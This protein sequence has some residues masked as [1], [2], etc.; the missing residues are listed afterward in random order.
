MRGDR[1]RPG[2]RYAGSLAVDDVPALRRDGAQA[3]T[4][5]TRLDVRLEATSAVE[6]LD[7]LDRVQRFAASLEEMGLEVVISGDMSIAVRIPIPTKVAEPE[8]D[9]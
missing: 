7:L 2:L 3:V 6:A 4:A 1:I 8:A 9:A 5:R